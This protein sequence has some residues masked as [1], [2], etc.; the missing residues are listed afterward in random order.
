MKYKVEDTIPNIHFKH[1][2][3]VRG[4]LDFHAV[5]SWFGQTYGACERLAHGSKIDNQHWSYE[6][7]YQNYTI[8]VK[9]DEELSWFKIKWGNPA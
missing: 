8:Y 5:R 7:I 3:K 9:G 1:S 2:I 6:V 4:M